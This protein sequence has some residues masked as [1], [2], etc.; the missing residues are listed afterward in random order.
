VEVAA[1]SAG[2]RRRQEHGEHGRHSGDHRPCH[3]AS[4]ARSRAK[5]VNS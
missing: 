2:A 1:L 5:K 4:P 3:L